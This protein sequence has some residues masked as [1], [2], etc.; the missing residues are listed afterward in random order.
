MDEAAIDASAARR[1]SRPE[2]GRRSPRSRRQRDLP[3]LVAE[4]HTI[5][6]N[7][8]FSF[9]AEADFKDASMVIATLDQ[10]GMGL[11]DRDYYFRDDARSVELREQYERARLQAWRRLAGARRRR[12]RRGGRNA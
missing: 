1:R 6:V 12:P 8:F 3:A 7:A 2:L 5:G 9:G 11:P 4:L 10:G